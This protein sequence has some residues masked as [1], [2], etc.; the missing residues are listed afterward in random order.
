[1]RKWNEKDLLK[2]L[3]FSKNHPADDQTIMI[4]WSSCLAINGQ[5]WQAGTDECTVYVWQSLN[6]LRENRRFDTHYSTIGLE[7]IKIQG[8]SF[9]T[10]G[11]KARSVTLCKRRRFLMKLTNL[12]TFSYMS[13]RFFWSTT[14]LPPQQRNYETRSGCRLASVRL[15]KSARRCMASFLAVKRWRES[16]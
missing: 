3:F 2:K 6:Y 4:V 11:K 14:S 16:F 7:S 8:L 1:M 13:N 12:Q 15:A 10:L 5:R 9:E